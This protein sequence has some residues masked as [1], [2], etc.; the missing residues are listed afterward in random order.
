M[1][2]MKKDVQYEDNKIVCQ[3]G[4]YFAFGKKLPFTLICTAKITGYDTVEF[5]LKAENETGFDI[6]AVY[7]PAPL[8]AKKK[9]KNSYAVDAMRNG[10][11][12]PDGYKKNFIST[13]GF[14]HYLRKN[15]HG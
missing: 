4:N 9:C 5:S 6:Q 1:S 15:Q 7:F 2:A 10:F 11:I 12:L 13:F 3:F 8:N 14:A